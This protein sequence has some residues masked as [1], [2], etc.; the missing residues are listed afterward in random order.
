M[1]K[2]QLALYY[3][4]LAIFPKKTNM[5]IIQ[6][7]PT[8]YVELSPEEIIV[9]PK[10]GICCSYPIW[11]GKNRAIMR[12]AIRYF[13]KHPPT[14]FT[15]CLG[16]ISKFQLNGMGSGSKVQESYFTKE[17]KSLDSEKVFW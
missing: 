7:H 10:R 15:E 2:N 11:L 9:C 17:E 16:I 5:K 3:R 6:A 13:E 4:G 14:T 12:D 8:F 1:G